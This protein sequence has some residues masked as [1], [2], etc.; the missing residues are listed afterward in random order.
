MKQSGTLKARADKTGYVGSAT[1]AASFTITTPAITT[2]SPVPAATA[3][4]S[5][6][7][8]LQV[9]GGQPAYKWTLV[10]SK[11]P[12]GLKLSSAGVIS[13]KPMKPTAGPVTFTVKVTDA[14]KGTTQQVFTLQVN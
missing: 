9:S 6:S 2:A 8:T 5:Y 10:K 14:K 7:Q 3:G 13:G 1:A 4:S 11:L 12:T